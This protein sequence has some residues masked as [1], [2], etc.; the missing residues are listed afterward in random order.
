MAVK[1]SLS[2][3]AA[4]A[5]PSD[6]DVL[7]PHGGTPAKAHKMTATAAIHAYEYEYRCTF[8][9]PHMRFSR[10]SILAHFDSRAFPGWAHSLARRI[11]S[12]VL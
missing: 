5:N 9:D 6:D 4:A 2:W 10:I 8:I 7:P 11:P 1:L 3:A 12:L